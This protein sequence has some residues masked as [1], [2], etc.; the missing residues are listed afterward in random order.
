MPAEF[1]A[2]TDAAEIDALFDRSKT[3]PVVI[4]K[5]DPYCPISM[6]AYRRMTQFSGDVV[7]VDVANAQALAS[8]ITERTGVRH[9]SPQVIVLKDGQ[10]VW[11]A[12][13]Y[14]ITPQAVT[15]AATQ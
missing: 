12:S 13:H 1:P 3:A 10:A 11:S 8:A 6:G 14:A 15:D 9:E 4:F 2:L 5:H 7:L